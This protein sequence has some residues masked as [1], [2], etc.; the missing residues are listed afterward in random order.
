MRDALAV[1]A[2]DAGRQIQE[3]SRRESDEAVNTMKARWGLTVHT[4]TPD[5]EQ[6][7]RAFAEAIYPTIRGTLVPADVFDEARRLVAEYRA[8]RR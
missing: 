7:W 2:T 8:S 1:P 3:S 4:L 6:Q 5:L